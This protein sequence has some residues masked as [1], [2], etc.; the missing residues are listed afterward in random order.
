[1]QGEKIIS[2]EDS[3]LA[4]FLNLAGFDVAFFVPTG[5]Q[6]IEKHFNKRLMEEHQI[7]EYVY[8]LQVPNMALVPPG[9][10]LSWRDRL[11]RRS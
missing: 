3:I 2:L 10:R 7:G 11:F 8:D 5:N 6:N 4:A 9:T 1:M